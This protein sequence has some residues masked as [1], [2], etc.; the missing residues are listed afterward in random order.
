MQAAD[1]WIVYIYMGFRVTLEEDR[2]EHAAASLMKKKN[3]KKVIYQDTFGVPLFGSK[4]S[5]HVSPIHKFRW[6]EQEPGEISTR[7]SYVPMWSQPA[8]KQVL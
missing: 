5:K 3:K 4:A 8:S 7:T 6:Q 2:T 1:C